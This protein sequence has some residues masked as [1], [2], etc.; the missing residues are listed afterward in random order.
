MHIRM[1]I[2]ELVKK[3]VRKSDKRLVDVTLAEKGEQLLEK[4]DQFQDEMD[5]ILKRRHK[6]A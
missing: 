5:S 4:M 1:V 3:V 6:R 2:K